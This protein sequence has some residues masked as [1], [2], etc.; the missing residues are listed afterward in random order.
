MKRTTEYYQ[1]RAS[2]DKGAQLLQLFVIVK[3]F[4]AMVDQVCIDIAQNQQRKKTISSGS[5]SPISSGKRIQVRFPNLP[6]HFMSDKLR[7][8][9]SDSDDEF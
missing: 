8:S 5:S 3:D 6:A 1:A 9:S 7:N 4:L 2:K